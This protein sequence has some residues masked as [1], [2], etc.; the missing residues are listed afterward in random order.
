ML[1]GT[2]S[3]V[4]KSL[5]V[6]GLC[7]ALRNRGLRVAPFKPQNKTNHAAVTAAGGARGRAPGR[8]AR[9]GGIAPHTDMNPVLLK[10]Q[11]GGAQIVVQGRVWRTAG[12]RDY[13]ALKG[14]LLPRVLESFGRLAAVHDAVVVEGA[15]SASEINLRRGDIANMGF[16]RA[17]GVPVVVV[18]DI[19]RGGVIASVVGTHAVLPPDDRAMVRG[20]VVNRMRGDA[21][22]FADGMRTIAAATGWP[23]LG[24]VPHLPAAGLLPREDSLDLAP[25]AVGVRGARLRV[26]IPLLPH[27]SN[28]DDFDPLAAEPGVEL[29]TLDLATPLPGDC[30]LV[31]LP[32]S[33]S[34][35]SDL[36]AL[37]QSGWEI[38]LAAHRRRGGR[39]LGVCGG[40][41]MLGRRV[42]DPD[43]VEGEAGETAG[44]GLLDVETVLTRDKRLAERGGTTC[45][46]GLPIDGYEM[47]LGVTTGP[48]TARPFATFADAPG[49]VATPDGAT[50]PDG[51][52][53]G[54]YLH[55]F[56]RAPAQRARLIGGAAT[57]THDDGETDRVLDILARHLERHMAIDPL[58]AIAGR[59]P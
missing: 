32:G 48:D 59:V 39:I 9:A 1:Q 27:I 18:G 19:D 14:E 54:T 17:A 8:P 2:G 5:L 20:F 56:L 24:L 33:K 52:V 10:P 7:R 57:S 12:A 23:A 22:L 15:G 42:V 29:L 43:G 13:Q 34:V 28:F 45:P 36:A 26:A 46:D 6:A 53:T 4:G 49:V 55:G 44:L 50:S 38:D 3:S 16:A 35:R 58:L 41:Q 11:D 37:R 21:T 47:H 25:S 31:I 51:R 40:L 30:D